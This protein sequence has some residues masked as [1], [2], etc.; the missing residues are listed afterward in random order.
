MIDFFSDNVNKYAPLAE[1]MRPRNLSEFVGQEHIIN[2][3]SMLT[4][5]I[6]NG[7]LGSVIFF[8][9]PGTGKT[10]LANIISLVGK[11]EFRKLNA[12]SSGVQDAKN[13]IMEA[14]QNLSMYGKRT[15][16]L[17]DE[18]H[19]W[20]KSQSDSVLQAVE[21]GSIIL[22][23]STTENPYTSMTRAIVSRCK[24][25]EFKP[26]TIDNI[27]YSLRK[28][29]EDERGLKHLNIE[30]SDETLKYLA[31]QSGG[32]LRT[33]LNNL[34]LIAQTTPLTDNKTIITKKEVDETKQHASY[35]IDTDSY[36]DVLSAFC[37][38]L[39]GSDTEAALYY[40]SVLLDSGIAPEIIA[41]RMIAHASEDIG[42]ADS[43]ALL[44]ANNAMFAVKNLGLPECRLNLSHA[45]I[46]LCEAPKSNSVYIAKMKAEE[47]SKK[48]PNPMVPNY[49][50]NHPTIEKEDKKYLYPHDFGGYVK[51]QYLPDNLKDRIYYLPSKN[52]REAN[53]ER[54]KFIVNKK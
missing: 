30:V 43:N 24:V 40:A 11:G 15:Y 21:E 20:N 27:T 1:R 35:S 12:V 4:R 52:G 54:K 8:G 3:N 33:A 22:I 34:E 53:I 7:T 39:R 23:G 28:A 31:N 45:I 16:L 10:T 37:K 5:A 18:C 46:Y 13:I 50:K 19:R 41:R 17:L 26:L 49:L 44:M 51:Q 42:M 25:Y 29:C 9:P 36:Y 14:R 32:D 48:Y 38:S 47:D 6:S 2:P